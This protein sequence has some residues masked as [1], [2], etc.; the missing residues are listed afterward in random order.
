MFNKFCLP[1]KF[2]PGETQCGLYTG[3]SVVTVTLFYSELFRTKNYYNN[4]SATQKTSTVVQLGEG[5]NGPI[6]PR[7]S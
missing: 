4:R 3:V 7:D 5:S 2:N 1:T 6:L